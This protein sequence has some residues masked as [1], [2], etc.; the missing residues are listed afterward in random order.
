MENVLQHH[1]ILGMKWGVRRTEAQLARARGSSSDSDD[2]SSSAKKTSASE[3]AERKKAVANRRTMST[4]ELKERIERLKLEKQF[5]DLTEEDLSPG[6]KAM[7]E[8]MT[9]AGKKVATAA[10]AGGIAYATRYALTKKFD[11][12]DFANYVASNPNKK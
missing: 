1:G 10:V 11:A 8:I 6:K 12:S 5:K 4:S 2:S 7:S 9:S 3:K